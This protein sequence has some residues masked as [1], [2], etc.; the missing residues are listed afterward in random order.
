MHWTYAVSHKGGGLVYA[1]HSERVDGQNV[2]ILMHRVIITRCMG[3]KRPSKKHFVDR[4]NGD[5][6]DNRRLAHDGRPL[7]WVTPRQNMPTSAG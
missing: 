1:R 2:T 6:L 4:W 3:L 7:R 5:A